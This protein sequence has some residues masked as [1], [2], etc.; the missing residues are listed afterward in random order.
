MITRCLASAVFAIALSVGGPV[1]AV[2]QDAE[3]AAED[4]AAPVAAEPAT[5][6]DRSAQNNPAVNE[7]TPELAQ[8]VER[9]FAYLDNQQ[10]TDGSF[11]RGRY[12]KHVGITAL[13]A[14]AYMADGNLPGRGSYGDNVASALEFVLDHSRPEPGRAQRSS[15]TTGDIG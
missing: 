2:P 14:I 8:S 5:S 3:P 13:C 15:M 4:P 9:G 10:N 7:L 11:G 6:E 12:G 1:H